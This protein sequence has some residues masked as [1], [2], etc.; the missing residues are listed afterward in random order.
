LSNP[1]IN[2]WGFNLFWYNLW[3]V[4]K[5][6]P[7]FIHSDIL[8]NRLVYTYVFFGLYFQKNFFLHSKWQSNFFDKMLKYKEKHE[9]QYFR[10]LEYRDRVFNKVHLAKSR[11]KRKNIYVSRFWIL[12]YQKWVIVNFYMFQPYKTRR[13]KKKKFRFH[14]GFSN[15]FLHKSKKKN[16]L[17]KY[18]LLNLF[19]YNTLFNQNAYYLF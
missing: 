17:Y 1:S 11:K 18:I 13:R 8:I 15:S 16:F 3:Y 7:F 9:L 2:R 4:D 14:S 5:N 6:S 19:Y 10:F 12:K